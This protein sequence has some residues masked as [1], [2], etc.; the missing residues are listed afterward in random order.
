MGSGYSSLSA[1]QLKLWSILHLSPAPPDG[2]DE[3]NVGCGGAPSWGGAGRPIGAGGRLGGGGNAESREGGGGRPN[4]DGGGGGGG[5]PNP[6]GGGGGGGKPREELGG[7]EG[8]GNPTEN[9]FAGEAGP[10]GGGGNK[11]VLLEFWL[12]LAT[13]TILF[14]GWDTS[15]YYFP[16][17]GSETTFLEIWL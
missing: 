14:I 11:E 3:E 16:W 1:R 6:E 8:G 17:Y 13:P 15:E 4:P 10:G 12:E 2:A 7:G 9:V 5:R